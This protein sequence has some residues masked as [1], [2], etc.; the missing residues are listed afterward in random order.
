MINVTGFTSRERKSY[1][2]TVSCD[3]RNHLNIQT[4]ALT[5]E[6]TVAT[7]AF[8]PAKECKVRMF[9]C[10]MCYRSIFPG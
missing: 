2:Q 3:T 9:N 6:L 5:R 7:Y 1:K 10:F 8:T 4:P